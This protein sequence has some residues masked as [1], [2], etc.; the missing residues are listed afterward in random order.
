[1][2][3]GSE[4]AEEAGTYVPVDPTGRNTSRPAFYRYLDALVID[5]G[6]WKVL[7]ERTLTGYP[8]PPGD[9]TNSPWPIENPF[10]ELLT[11]LQGL[12]RS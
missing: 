2:F 1:V 11:Y 8:P 9:I 6:S 3:I 4:R 12:P 10:P 7:D 5:A